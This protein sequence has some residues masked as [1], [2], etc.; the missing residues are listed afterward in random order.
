[1]VLGSQPGVKRRRSHFIG[2]TML[3]WEGLG[4]VEWRGGTYVFEAEDFK[5]GCICRGKEEEGGYGGEEI[6]LHFLILLSNYSN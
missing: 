4:G 3:V 6:E 5:G 1:M 2:S